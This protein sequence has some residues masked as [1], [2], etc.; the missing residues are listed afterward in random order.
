MSKRTPRMKQKKQRFLEILFDT[1]NIAKASRDIGITRQT[2]Y[3]WKKKDKKFREAWNEIEQAYLDDCAEVVFD[4]A[5]GKNGREMPNAEMAYRI[6]ARK[7]YKE[8]GNIE[9]NQD[10][11]VVPVQILLGGN[12]M[13]GLSPEPDKE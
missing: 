11:A 7:R 4:D 10:D 12:M 5:L 6:L 13:Q 2:A 1:C 3:Q 8:W 9:K